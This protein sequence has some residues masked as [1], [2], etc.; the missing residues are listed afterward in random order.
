MRPNLSMS[1]FK[2]ILSGLN[3]PD[4]TGSMTSST[5][6]LK[7]AFFELP[8]HLGSDDHGAWISPFHRDAKNDEW[9]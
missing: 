8:M 2:I 7:Q 1:T 4:S 6:H 5:I 9:R 3:L